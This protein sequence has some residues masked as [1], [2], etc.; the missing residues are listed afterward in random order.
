MNIGMYFIPDLALPF[1]II[2]TIIAEKKEVSVSEKTANVLKSDFDT[3]APENESGRFAETTALV[4][5]SKAV[6]MLPTTLI[7]IPERAKRKGAAT[8]VAKV[9]NIT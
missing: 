2:A 1:F 4:V 7:S 3:P 9:M 5:E 8:I 6:E